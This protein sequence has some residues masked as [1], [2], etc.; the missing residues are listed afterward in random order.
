MAKARAKKTRTRR[1]ETK[2]EDRAIRAA[3]ELIAER[4]WRAFTLDAMAERAGLTAVEAR[5]LY[6]SR[7]AVLDAF[8]RQVDDAVAAEGS[9]AADDPNSA[10][11]RL[12]DVLMRRF[13]AL[14]P[15]RAA[16]AALA[17]ELPL[18]PRAAV[19][20][21]CRIVRAIKAALQTAG[22][23]AK[24]PIGIARIKG[25]GI[26]Y[27]YALRVWLD[28]ESPDLSATMAALDRGLRAAEGAMSA[29]GAVLGA[30]RQAATPPPPGKAERNP[31]V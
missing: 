17:R 12:F 18:D 28:D 3:L 20:A 16:M 19:R 31:K 5:A 11:D 21:A 26:I 10:R 22:L 27:L 4:G 6:P 30:V 9:Y 24:G 23:A 2:S 7:D 14:N 29:F 13:D 25:L 1:R 8:F 15:H